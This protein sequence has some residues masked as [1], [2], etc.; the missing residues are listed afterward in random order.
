VG[1]L[2]RREGLASG[3]KGSDEVLLSAS[4]IF[5]APF[6]RSRVSL[7]WV[8]ISDL[9]LVLSDASASY[10]MLVPPADQSR[11]TIGYRSLAPLFAQQL[12]D[13]DLRSSLRIHALHDY[14]AVQVVLAALAR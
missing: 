10:L 6:T 2:C 4:T 11:A 12:V 5:A 7:F 3:Q 13:A 8:F 1:R 14:R 9:T